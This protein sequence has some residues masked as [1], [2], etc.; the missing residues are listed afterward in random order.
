MEQPTR[1]W[2][3]ITADFVDMPSTKN[4]D[5]KETMDQVVVV[6]DS[7]W[8]FSKQTIIIPARKKHEYERDLWERIFSKF[9]ILE[10]IISDRDEIFRSDEWQRLTKEIRS[11]HILITANHQQTDGQSE[12][13]IHEIQACL[14]NY[15]DYD[16]TNG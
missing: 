14:R 10:T 7:F 15:S 6:A 13:K 2:S 8:K 3:H 9:G 11:M 12:S 4:I 1:P 16:Q 5:R